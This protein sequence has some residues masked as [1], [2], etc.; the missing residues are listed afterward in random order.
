MPVT[1]QPIDCSRVAQMP[2]PYRDVLGLTDAQ[3]S[4]K[5]SNAINTV[6][7]GNPATYSIFTSDSTTGTAYIRDT[8]HGDEVRTE[9]MGLGMLAAVLLDHQPEFDQLWRYSVAN[10]EIKTGAATGYY[11]SRC[12]VTETTQR[13]CIDPYGFQ[14]YV[15]ALL[16]ANQRWGKVDGSPDYAADALQ[17]LTVIRTKMQQNGGIVDGV[18]NT[19]DP[20]QYL[21]YD[22]PVNGGLPYVG[23]ALAIPGYYDLFAQVTGDSFF[24]EAAAASRVFLKRASHPVTGLFPNAASFDGV[25]VSGRGNFL[26]EAYRVNLNLVIDRLWGNPSAEDAEWQEPIADRMLQFFTS[27]GFDTYASGYTLDG[28]VVLKSEHIDELV[29]A[30]AVL[31]SVSNVSDR[32]EYL[33]AAWSKAPPEGIARYYAGLMYLI[34]NLI[35]SG[36]FVPC[37]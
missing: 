37:P 36:Q 35:L 22:E 14:Q 28:S 29:M 4:A 18:T 30:N 27:K 1:L 24:S 15:T 7:H 5:L 6:F 19:F 23:T 16:I 26:A 13:D 12:D 9:G 34:G 17:L 8:L 2:N 20:V 33:A 10:L 32:K 25:P 11:R 31:A 3:I 21:P